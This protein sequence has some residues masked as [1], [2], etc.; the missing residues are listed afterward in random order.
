M[1]SRED[2]TQ[3]CIH[4]YEESKV[5]VTENAQEL[6][7]ILFKGI[8]ED[9]HQRW[10]IRN[11][12]EALEQLSERH[13]GTLPA[14]LRGVFRR[15]HMRSTMRGISREGPRKIT[16]FDL[17]PQLGWIVETFCDIDCD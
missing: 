6:L 17:A 16:T 8:V 1:I 3:I 10:E 15:T 4:Y 14:Y 13:A 5:E 12:R 9:P 7:Y 2:I 11:N